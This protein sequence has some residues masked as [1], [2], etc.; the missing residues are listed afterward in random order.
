MI[1]G[2]VNRERA[3][4]IKSA[5]ITLLDSWGKNVHVLVRVK[6]QQDDKWP[7]EGMTRFQIVVEAQPEPSKGKGRVTRPVKL[8]EPPKP[9]GRATKPVKLPEPS[10]PKGRATKPV[11]LPDPTSGR[12]SSGRGDPNA[13]APTRP[14]NRGLC[15]TVGK[16]TTV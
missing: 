7:Q 8:P 13:Y 10:K 14:G 3:Y 9:K 11:K 6:W 5:L 1:H 12:L 4:E 15:N 16:Y 2:R